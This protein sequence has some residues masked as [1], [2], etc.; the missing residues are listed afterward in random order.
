MEV[1]GLLPEHSSSHSPLSSSSSS[2]LTPSLAGEHTDDPPCYDLWLGGAVA[3]IASADDDQDSPSKGPGC[4]YR[5]SVCAYRHHHPALL[6]LDFE[7]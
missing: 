4:T 7:L 6:Q 1:Q 5:V 3:L 2:S